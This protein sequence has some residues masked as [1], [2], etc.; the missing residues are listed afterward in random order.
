MG[1]IHPMDD[2]LA[3]TL[4]RDTLLGQTSRFAELVRGFES[5]VYNLALRMTGSAA[6][7][8][9]LT[10]ETFLRAWLNLDKYN[11]QHKFFTWLYTLA[12]NLIRNHLKKTSRHGLMLSALAFPDQLPAEEAPAANPA[13]ALAT[14]QKG[15]AIQDLLF[16]L[17]V[18]QREAL[19]LRFFQDMSF[20]ELATILGVSQ[21]AAKMRVRRGLAALREVKKSGARD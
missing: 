13:A 16:H 14:K 2:D 12:L 15:R 9:D 19:L 6:D 18:E 17:P 10:Q 21:S 4:V 11:Q 8:A 5:P 1:Y 20:A 3:G 7:A